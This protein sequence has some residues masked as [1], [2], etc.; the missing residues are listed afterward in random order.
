MKRVL[1][2]LVLFITNLTF[3]QNNIQ[4]ASIGAFK[5]EGGG[6]IKNCKIGYRTSGKLNNEKSNVILWIPWLTGKSD[7]LINFIPSLMDTTGLYIIAVDPLSNGESSSP[8][9]TSN[10]PSISI[11]DMVKVDHD[12]LINNLMINHVKAIIGFSMGGMETFEWMVSYPDFMDNVIPI[13]GTP[14]QS[15]Y[16]ILLCQ[17]E[18]NIILQAKKEKQDMRIAM[19]R[20][21]DINILHDYTPQYLSTTKSPDSVNVFLAKEYKTEYNADNYFSQLQAMISQDIYKSSGRVIADIK[22]LIKCKVLV[23]VTSQDL[24]V[25][26]LNAIEFAKVNNYR[27]VEL[28]GVFGHVSPFFKTAE[29]KQAISEFLK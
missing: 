10:F 14:K 1:F 28:S 21:T 18:S 16:D 17:T 2:I 13:G 6:I 15:F 12:F 22:N 24:F 9:N 8:S 20:V 4:I 11:R 19:Q 5:T 26:P 29:I 23:I 27:L 7:F 3:G 25:N